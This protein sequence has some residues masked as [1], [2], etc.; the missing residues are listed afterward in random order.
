MYD[1]GLGVT[2]NRETSTSWYEKAAAKGHSTALALLG[3]NNAAE[4]SVQFN[5]QSMRLSAAKSLPSEY[6]KKFLTSK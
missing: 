3:R 2:A 6:A 1:R 4:G 5:Y